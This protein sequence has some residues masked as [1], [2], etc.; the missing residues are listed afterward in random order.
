MT[1]TPTTP[2][3]DVIDLPEITEQM[4]ADDIRTHMTEYHNG[5]SWTLS[6]YLN[7]TPGVPYGKGFTKASKEHLVMLHE[8]LHEGN[9]IR[10]QHEHGD[11]I[12]ALVDG[13][14]SDTRASQTPGTTPRL[15]NA[16]RRTLEKLVDYDFA[17]LRGEIDQIAADTLQA[18]LEG[19]DDEFKDQQ[20]KANRY[21]AKY[22][23]MA[24]KHNAAVRELIEQAK[25]EGISVVGNNLIVSTDASVGIVDRN[26]R[27]NKLQEENRRDKE[28]AQRTLER[29]R[30]ET[31]RT[32]LLTGLGASAE[33]VLA[34]IPTAQQLMVAAAQERAEL[35]E[36][37]A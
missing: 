13:P 9:V 3:D 33:S 11:A 14:D 32:V 8:R 27:V 36:L 37:M 28:R 34:A 15:N 25:D 12:D 19:L 26:E 6:G 10:V 4:T 16:E 17:S 35:K 1:E 24:E 2:V 21:A 5:D 31:Q 30:L 18:R 23:Q 22:R 20:I 29:K 7:S